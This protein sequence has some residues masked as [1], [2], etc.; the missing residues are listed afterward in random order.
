[1]K[2]NLS[3]DEIAAVVKA[4]DIHRQA[5]VRRLDRTDL[6]PQ[7]HKDAIAE[8]VSLTTASTALK[9]AQDASLAPS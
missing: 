1:M 6:T 4:V 8:I 2:M 7:A 3:S 9:E 5:L